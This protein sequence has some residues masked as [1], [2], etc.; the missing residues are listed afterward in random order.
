MSGRL[1]WLLLGATAIALAFLIG[2]LTRG[3]EVEAE[4]APARAHANPGAIPS[5]RLAALEARLAA[6][7]HESRSAE[8]ERAGAAASDPHAGPDA[9]VVPE[10]NRGEPALELFHRL[11]DEAQRGAPDAAWR[12]EQEIWDSL[13]GAAGLRATEVKCVETFCRVD[14]TY[15]SED[16]SA[17][18]KLI[19][20][21]TTRSPYSAGTAF[22]QGDT[23]LTLYVQRPGHPLGNGLE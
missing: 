11:D 2:R 19:R 20:E 14:T 12:P 10:E 18:Q 4:A 7:E 6:V 13:A 9:V 1:R 8:Q 21:L 17:A 5:T 22:K 15:T 3:I 23:G 16:R